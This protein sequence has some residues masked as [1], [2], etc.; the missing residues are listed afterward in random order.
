VAGTTAIE[1]EDGEDEICVAARLISEVLDKSSMEPV[2]EDEE[3][4]AEEGSSWTR[5]KRRRLSV[6]GLD[7]V[8]SSNAAATLRHSGV[9]TN[10]INRMKSSVPVDSS[11]ATTSI[12]LPPSIFALRF[13]RFR[14]FGSSFCFAKN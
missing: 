6:L 7:L 9:V 1:V 12:S 13:P 4:V 10:C 3:A 5:M 11:E 8:I 14:K 2:A